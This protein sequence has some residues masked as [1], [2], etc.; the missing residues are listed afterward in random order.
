MVQDKQEDKDRKVKSG[1]G[2]KEE[3]RKQIKVELHVK[4]QSTLP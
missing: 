3:D 2:R 4:S 1:H